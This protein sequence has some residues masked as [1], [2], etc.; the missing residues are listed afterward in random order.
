L[1]S[2]VFCLSPATRSRTTGRR[3]HRKRKPSQ[4]AFF[5][6]TVI[7]SESDPNLI[8]RRTYQFERTLGKDAAGTQSEYVTGSVPNT[9]T[10]NIPSADKINADFVFV[11]GGKENRTGLDGLKAG[12]RATAALGETAFNTSSDVVRTRMTLESDTNSDATPLFGY[13]STATINVNNNITANKAVGTIGAFDV[14]A[15]NFEANGS[16]TAYFTNTAALGAIMN[17]SEAGMYTIAAVENQG[18]VFDLPSLTLGG[19]KL[20]V[21]LNKPITVPLTSQGAQ[22]K[23]GHTM[24]FQH[25]AYLPNAAMPS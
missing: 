23:F 3:S 20:A 17:G 9:L 8:K 22:S 4:P 11:A 16:V 2:V 13:V 25:F 6:G 21:E 24:L 7:R 14:S 19:G 12:T 10:V 15:G 5:Y 18:I 1:V